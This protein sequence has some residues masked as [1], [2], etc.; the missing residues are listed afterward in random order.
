MNDVFFI[1][2]EPKPLPEWLTQAILEGR[3]IVRSDSTS[4]IPF[5]VVDGQVATLG[6]TL[7]YDGTNITI[8]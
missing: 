4:N 8:N 7:I 1:N 3:V 6:E 2:A 5:Y